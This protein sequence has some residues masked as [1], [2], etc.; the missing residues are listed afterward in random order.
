MFIIL[1]LFVI[2]WLVVNLLDFIYADIIASSAF[3]LALLTALVFLFLTVFELQP[4]TERYPDLIA[5]SPMLVYPVYLF[6]HHSTAM[7]ELMILLLQG[8]GLL[9]LLLLAVHYASADKTGALNLA[10]SLVLTVLFIE[11]WF[12]QPPIDWIPEFRNVL[13]GLSAIS[14]TYTLPQIINQNKP[15]Y[16]S[17]SPG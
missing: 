12:I 6:V 2:T 5:F 4:E 15:N 16:A 17:Q 14:L 7:Q 10:G 1:Y 11:Y 8:G 9:V 3:I 13:F